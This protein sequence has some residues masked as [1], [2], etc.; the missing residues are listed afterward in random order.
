VDHEVHVIEQH[1]LRLP[2]AF[3]VRRL[4]PSV[5]KSLL[6]LI[7]DGLNLPRVAAGTNDEIVGKRPAVLPQLQ[8]RDIG[9]FFGFAGLQGLED[10]LAGFGV[11]SRGSGGGTCACCGLGHSRLFEHEMRDVGGKFVAL[12]LP[13]FFLRVF[14]PSW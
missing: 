14:V 10:A 5:C 2:V 13:Y 7:R 11:G 1:P 8:N 4:H 12:V 3:H 9:G 6:Y